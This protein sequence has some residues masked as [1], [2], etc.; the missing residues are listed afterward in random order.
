MAVQCPGFVACSGLAQHLQADFGSEHLGQAT[1]FVSA[2]QAAW[3][4]DIVT[5]CAA[6]VQCMPPR[7]LAVE[8]GMDGARLWM[9]HLDKYDWFDPRGMLEQWWATPRRQH[10]RA[11]MAT[12]D[13]WQVPSLYW[14]MMYWHHRRCVSAPPTFPLQ[15]K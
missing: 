7:I 9:R 13:F 11:I 4:P 2:E 8:L 3:L 15:H 1:Q 5:W 12:A 6:F 10:W 14:R